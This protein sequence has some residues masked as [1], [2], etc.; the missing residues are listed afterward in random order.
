MSGAA[1]LPSP[2]RR[3]TTCLAQ[4]SARRVWPR[5]IDVSLVSYF[6]SSRAVRP[7]RAASGLTRPLVRTAAYAPRHTP[8]PGRLPARAARGGPPR[9]R[10]PANAPSANVAPPVACAIPS[11]A[12]SKRSHSAGVARDPTSATV[13]C[14]LKLSSHRSRRLTLV[15]STAWTCAA[16]LDRS[17]GILARCLDACRRLAPRPRRPR[18][19]QVSTGAGS[20]RPE[21]AA[22]GEAATEDPAHAAGSSAIQVDFRRPGGARPT[23]HLWTKPAIAPPPRC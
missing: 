20:S 11:A 13:A 5:L 15:C 2:P 21:R 10:R 19:P 14:E 4:T 7:H 3:P 18:H 16:A 6:R 22:A 8:H 23:P 17:R 12:P 9:V 1:A